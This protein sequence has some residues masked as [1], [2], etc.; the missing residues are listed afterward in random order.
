MNILRSDFQIYIDKSFDNFS[1]LK[2]VNNCKPTIEDGMEFYKQA[3][4]QILNTMNVKLQLETSVKKSFED[5]VNK[6]YDR[7]Q[8]Y[9][10]PTAYND[11]FL[12]FMEKHGVVINTIYGVKGEEYT[13]VIAFGLLNGRLPKWVYITKSDKKLLD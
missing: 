8:R 7:I 4:N 2:T 12:C 13:T 3:T 1:L 5:F 11:F 6:C 10:L 9:E